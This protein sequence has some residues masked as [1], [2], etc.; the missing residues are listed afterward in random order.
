MLAARRSAARRTTGAWL[1][2]PRGVVLRE[3]SQDGRTMHPATK[4]ADRREIGW[5]YYGDLGNMR[6]GVWWHRTGFLVDK[7]E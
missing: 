5:V 2:G 6:E 1:F 4:P 3:L 7:V